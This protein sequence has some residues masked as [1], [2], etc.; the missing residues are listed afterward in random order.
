VIICNTGPL[1]AAALSNDADHAGNDQINGEVV[2]GL[3]DGLV[4]HLERAA[5]KLRLK[6]SATDNIGYRL[7]LFRDLSRLAAMLPSPVE[8]RI[9][10]CSSCCTVS[11]ELLGSARSLAFKQDCDSFSKSAKRDQ[12]RLLATLFAARDERPQ[13]LHPTFMDVRIFFSTT[14]GV[15]SETYDGV[16]FFT[17]PKLRSVR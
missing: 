10:D 4:Y 2:F 14:H 13:L 11:L 16:V 15:K 3:G 5:Q 8:L 12:D 1:V 7:I 9:S 17:K 6:L